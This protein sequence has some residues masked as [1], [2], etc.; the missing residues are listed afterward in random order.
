MAVK[1]VTSYWA[2]LEM[3]KVPLWTSSMVSL[4]D[5]ALSTRSDLCR[6]I[7]ASPIREASAMAGTIRPWGRATA[8]PTL[9]CGHM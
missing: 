5:R 9:T 2:R 1:A 7:S 6:L 8:R 4:P 3:V